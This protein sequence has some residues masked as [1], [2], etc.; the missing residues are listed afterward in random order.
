[1]A[2]SPG[3]NNVRTLPPLLGGEGW[4]E[5][6]PTNHTCIAELKTVPQSGM[7]LKTPSLLP[8]MRSKLPCPERKPRSDSP[9][10]KLPAGRQR[11]IIASLETLSHKDVI[12][13][14]LQTDHIEVS[15]SA[16]CHFKKWYLTR[17][18]A[19]DELILYDRIQSVADQS[20]PPLFR[21]RP[22]PIP[23]RR[24]LR[25]AVASRPPKALRRRGATEKPEPRTHETPRHRPPIP[26]GLKT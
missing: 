17:N 25:Q 23:P 3:A 6:K 15:S 5:G 11:Q 13:G 24:Q 19:L 20:A 12:A 14:L 18:Q 4:G 1:M 22:P 9:L 7:T 21:P 8:T 16:L 26:S 10:R 2:M